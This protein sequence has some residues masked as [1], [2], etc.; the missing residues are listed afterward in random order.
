MNLPSLRFTPII[1]PGPI[2]PFSKISLLSISTIPVSEPT[3]KILFFVIEYLIG[4]KPF[5]SIPAITQSLPYAAIAA[6]PSH[7]SKTE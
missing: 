4:L 6:G 3:N 1:C 7:G 5:L 2:C